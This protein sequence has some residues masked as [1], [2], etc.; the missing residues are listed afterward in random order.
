MLAKSFFGKVLMS[1]IVASCICLAKS[2]KNSDDFSSDERIKPPKYEAIAAEDLCRASDNPKCEEILDDFC[3]SNKAC[4]RESC[5]VY[6]SIRGM[7]RLLCEAEGLSPECLK[8]GPT[9]KA[10]KSETEDQSA[11]SKGEQSESTSEPDAASQQQEQQQQAMFQQQQMLAQQQMMRQ[12]EMMRQQQ[13]QQMML[14]Q[15]QMMPQQQ[16]QQMM[17]QQATAPDTQAPGA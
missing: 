4:S 13:Q 8:M 7:C 14:Q 11:A 5:G 12:Q 1:A 9:K 10:V 3:D 2:D 15:Q 17:P 16:Q 6:G